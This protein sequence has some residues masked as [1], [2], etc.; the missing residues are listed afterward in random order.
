MK[1]LTIFILTLLILTSCSNSQ[2]TSSITSSQKGKY[3]SDIPVCIESGDLN[4]N[5]EKSGPIQLEV[6]IKSIQV[7]SE[8]EMVNKT[9]II[10]LDKESDLIKFEKIYG[11]KFYHAE[12]YEYGNIVHLVKM[13]FLQYKASKKC[14]KGHDFHYSEKRIS[15]ESS[16]QSG[17]FSIGEGRDKPGFIEVHY[18][19]NRLK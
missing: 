5:V 11:L 10:D 12:G 7:G 1:H 18:A 3:K 16:S 4:P 15:R 9:Q 19:V 13:N 6:T 8:I 2:K 14:W 17:S